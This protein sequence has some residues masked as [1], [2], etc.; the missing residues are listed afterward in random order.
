[1]ASEEVTGSYLT[2][3]IVFDPAPA[4]QSG[5]AIALVF[6]GPGTCYIEGS[7]TDLYSGQ[8]LWGANDVTGWQLGAGDLAFETHIDP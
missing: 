7:A 3:R 8:S 4:V 1:M 2:R 6:T 5:Q